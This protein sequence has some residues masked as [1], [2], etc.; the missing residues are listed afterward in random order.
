MLGRVSS[1]R[2][3]STFWT[4]SGSNVAANEMPQGMKVVS[5]PY[6]YFDPLAPAGPSVIFKLGIPSLL[7]FAVSHMFFPASRETF[8]S[9]V[10][11]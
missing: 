9:N 10:K 4:N 6:V 11:A 8:S 1:P 3:L 2:T 5:E 7:M